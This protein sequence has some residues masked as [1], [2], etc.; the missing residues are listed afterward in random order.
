MK[1]G[2]ALRSNSTQASQQMKPASTVPRR[3]ALFQDTPFTHKA[4]V[5]STKGTATTRSMA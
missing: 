3:A 2:M 5:A 4:M 1:A